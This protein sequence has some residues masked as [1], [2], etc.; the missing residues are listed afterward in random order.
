MEIFIVFLF[1][2]IINDVISSDG[3]RSL[4]ILHFNPSN[5][6]TTASASNCQTANICQA[7]HCDGQI[8]RQTDR[9]QQTETDT[10]SETA[11][12]LCFNQQR[13]VT[14]SQMLRDMFNTTRNNMRVGKW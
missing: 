4:N 12:G 10:D 13:Q 7:R 2:F 14:E 8:D 5:H 11:E 6:Q 3:I 1:F 9:Q